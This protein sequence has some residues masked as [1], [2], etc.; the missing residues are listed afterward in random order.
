MLPK[1]ANLN[2]DGPF[3]TKQDLAS[4][5]KRASGLF[6]PTELG[7]DGVK[8]PIFLFGCGGMSTPSAYAP[9]LS[10]IASHGFVVLA[11]VS[12]IGDN[13][14]VFKASLDWIV[15]ENSRMGSPFYGKLDTTKIAA[16]GHSIGSVN[17]FAFGTDPRLTTTIHVA[18]GS[19]D[20]A[21]NPN[22][23]TTGMGGKALIHPT[24][25]ICDKNDTFANDTKAA[26][27][28]KATTAPVF[29]T[30][31]TGTDH[32]GVFK[33]ALPAIVGWLRW[34]LGGEVERR[35]MFLDPTG[36]FCSGQ[37]MSVSKNW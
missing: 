11:D 7:K 23:P 18:G 3:Q 17:A 30:L 21:N 9:E 2:G 10:R 5:P 25:Y 19:L 32:I 24:A 28:Y 12:A 33:A 16:G 26:A 34:Q 4:G 14:T 6:Q 22:A 35:S 37:Y 1:V 15:A 27:D 36:E 31:M 29:F 8:H 20:D 13:A